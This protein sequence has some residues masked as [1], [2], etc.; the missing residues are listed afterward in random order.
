MRCPASADTHL[1]HNF[2]LTPHTHT[3]PNHHT[4]AL[5]PEFAP[6]LQYVVP[7]ALASCKLDDGTW[8]DSSSEDEDKEDASH[9][10]FAA[11][12]GGSSSS[13]RG[14][15]PAHGRVGGASLAA[16]DD[17][18]EEDGGDGGRFSV[19]TGGG[20]DRAWCGVRGAVADAFPVCE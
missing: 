16:D 18:D 10:T 14:S 5:G 19:R 20:W 1:T 4:Q 2:V 6:Y 8:N 9:R 11:N 13:G 7:L 3:Q 12:G 17:S 15:D